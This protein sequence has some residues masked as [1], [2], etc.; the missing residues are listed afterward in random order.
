MGRFYGKVGYAI[1]V[2]KEHSIWEE[3][4]VERPYYGDILSS[5]SKWIDSGKINDDLR[6]SEKISIVADPFACKNFSHIKY[7]IV[8]GVKW[9][10]VQ[11]E[12]ARPRIILTLGGEYNEQ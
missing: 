11:A 9:K 5:Y 2:E 7:V 12:P 10:V 6:I 1:T 3:T 8:M 4:I